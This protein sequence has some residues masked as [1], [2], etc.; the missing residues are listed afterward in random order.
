[1]NNPLIVTFD[2]TKAF[3]A[4]ISFEHM[5][6]FVGPYPE[7]YGLVEIWDDGEWKA[8][9]IVQ[10]DSL[11]SWQEL[12]LDI[13]AYVGGDDFTQIR[14]LMISNMTD[15]GTEWAIRNFNVQG[16]ID[17]INPTVDASLSP[18]SPNGDN[19]WYTS[20]VTVTIMG[21]DNRKV[22]TIY[23]RIDGGTWKV[24]TSPITISVDG[25]HTVDYYCV[26]DV[27]NPS[28]IGSV[29]FKIDSTNPTASIT[30]PQA[31][32]IYLMGRELFA[33]PL[34]GTIIIGGFNFAASASDG[35]SGLDH[36]SFELDGY[37]YDDT[38]SPYE[39]WW[40]K[41]DLMPTQYTLTVASYDLAGNKSP[42]A[43][44]NFRHWL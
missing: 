27:G 10:G 5:Y 19:G 39:I 44:L 11:G 29:S 41:F 3:E 37:T 42:D 14:F 1:M 25:A 7:D 22:E 17:L 43:T 21:Y 8:L 9:F 20:P 35:G 26:D 18:A 16:K 4:F 32:Y 6:G 2:L 40:H 38:S 34:G 33:N 23:Y 31:G 12:E 36:V 15:V 28:D 24:Y 30:A 13:S